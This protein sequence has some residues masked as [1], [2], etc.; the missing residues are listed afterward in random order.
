[1]SSSYFSSSSRR[2][3]FSGFI[4][5]ELVFLLAAV[6]LSNGNIKIF[7]AVITIRI[8]IDFLTFFLILSQFLHIQN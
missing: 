2:R 3:R 7:L 4:L 6:N 1:M 5:L 8:V